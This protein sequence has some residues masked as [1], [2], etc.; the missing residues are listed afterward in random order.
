[1]SSDYICYNSI[2]KMNNIMNKVFNKK[3]INNFFN[4][5]MGYSSVCYKIINKVFNRKYINNFFNHFMGHTPDWYKI[6]ILCLLFL[7][8]ICLLIAGG[9]IT[10]WII[11]I[12]FI[13][14]LALSLKCYPLLPGGL[15]AIETV[16]MG[17]VTPDAVYKEVA[18]NLEVILL[19]I[20]MI[21]GIYFMKEFLTWLFT[22]ILFI[23]RSKIILSLLFCFLG[24][25][26]SAWLDAL[27]VTAVIITVCLGFY[28]VYT[29]TSYDERVQGEMTEAEKKDAGREDLKNFN[30]FL[31]NLLMHGAVGTAIGGV[32]T[33]VGEPQNILIGTLMG[34]NFMDFFMTMAHISIPV[35]V[36][37]MLTV[38]VVEKFKL[39]GY[40]YKLPE[41]VRTI[42][43]QNLKKQ[44]ADRD[45]G[46]Y[47]KIV[48]QAIT[49]VWLIVALA[50]HLASV[51]LIGLSVI[52]ILTAVNGKSEESQIGK[53]FQEAMPFTALLVVFF[54]VVAMIHSNSLFKPIIDAALA[55]PANVQVSTFF[56]ASGILSAISDNVFVATIYIQE[57]LT[58]FQNN[59]ID[60]HQ[61]NLLA[62]AINAGTNIPS[63]ATPNGQ[64]AFLF[65]L[66]SSL[67]GRIKLSYLRML[68]LAIPYTIVLTTT[69]FVFLSFNWVQYE[70]PHNKPVMIEKTKSH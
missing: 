41:R 43:E 67:A 45:T 65:L 69:A 26:M 3:Y 31:C 25:F 56:I 23:S 36:A 15:I 33:I 57:A 29:E 11:L 20:F 49:F 4:C 58:A 5:F 28:E 37:G 18:Y 44:K 51:G 14:T 55:K 32:S 21:S 39:F 6:L 60:L 63:V 1:M 13:F 16:F 8:P 62:I 46:Y 10:G 7:N 27:T 59:L 52:I 30:G 64:A 24:A 47:F 2:Q 66:T 53:A 61:L 40:G 9:Y 50:F 35:F 54:A 42:L 68:T 22:K 12:E 48:T 70:E 19:L 34:W 38:I 17:M